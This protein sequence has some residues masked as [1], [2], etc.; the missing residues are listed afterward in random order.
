MAPFRI[1]PGRA[2]VPGDSAAPV[3]PAGA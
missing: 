1:A 3:R 2:S